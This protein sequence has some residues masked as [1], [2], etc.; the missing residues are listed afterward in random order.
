MH[1]HSALHKARWMS[2]I[3]YIMKM[4]FLNRKIMEFPKGT[5][6]AAQKFTKICKFVQFVVYCYV[7]WWLTAPVSTS[8]SINDLKLVK[9]LIEYKER[10][11]NI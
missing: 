7:P 9:T 11:F 2:K 8:A 5:I 1:I 3:F 10:Q 6:F 4:V